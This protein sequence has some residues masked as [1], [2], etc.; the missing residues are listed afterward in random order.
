MATSAISQHLLSTT[1]VAYPIYF[2]CNMWPDS[3]IGKSEKFSRGSAISY[4]LHLKSSG[5]DIFGAATILSSIIISLK[6]YDVKKY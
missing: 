4:N 1:L 3:S 2:K 5:V 6:R